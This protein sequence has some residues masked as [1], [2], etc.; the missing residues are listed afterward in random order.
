MLI[1]L[2]G[3]S[4]KMGESIRE[5]AAHSYEIADFK[6]ADLQKNKPDVTIDFSS[7]DQSLKVINSCLELKIPLVIGTTGLSK[8]QEN[9]IKKTLNCHQSF[10]LQI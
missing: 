10:I 8:E 6:S 9:I 4:G 2:S 1:A 5:L 7:P 3:F